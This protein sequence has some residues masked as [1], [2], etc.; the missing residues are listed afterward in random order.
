M[1]VVLVRVPRVMVLAGLAP[2]WSWIRVQGALCGLQESKSWSMS[3]DGKLR[4]LTW[5]VGNETV[6]LQHSVNP[7]FAC[8]LPAVKIRPWAASGFT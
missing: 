7:M 4:D 2:P 8:G 3:R 6:T 5:K 1:R